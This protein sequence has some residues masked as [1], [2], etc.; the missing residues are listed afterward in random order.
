MVLDQGQDQN[1]PYNDIP[2]YKDFYR[3]GRNTQFW[4]V[5]LRGKDFGLKTLIIA[6]QLNQSL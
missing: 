1:R 6:H 2:L 5:A 3:N 4:L